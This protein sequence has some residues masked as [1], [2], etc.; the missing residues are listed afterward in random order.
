MALLGWR[1]ETWRQWQLHGGQTV[2]P[3]MV[4][5]GEMQHLLRDAGRTLAVQRVHAVRDDFA[6]M[7]A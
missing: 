6:D 4:V 3:V 1:C 2:D 7:T 5:R